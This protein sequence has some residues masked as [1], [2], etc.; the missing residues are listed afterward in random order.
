MRVLMP[1]GLATGISMTGLSVF[2]SLFFSSSIVSEDKAYGPVGVVMVLISYLVGLGVVIHRGGVVGRKWNERHRP[3]RE[4]TLGVA[5]RGRPAP[6]VS[7][8]CHSTWRNRAETMPT[9]IA[10]EVMTCRHVEETRKAT[11]R[12]VGNS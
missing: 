6:R 10:R 7:L 12:P 2:S 11:G 5:G 1:T 4:M 3:I 9:A 8:G